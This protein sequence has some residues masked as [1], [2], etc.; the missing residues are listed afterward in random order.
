MRSAAALL[1][2]TLAAVAVVAYL[3]TSRRDPVPATLW[4]EDDD[5]VQADDYP[6]RVLA[7]GAA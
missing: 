6:W 4:R 1:L 5:A 2:A 7:R 3:A